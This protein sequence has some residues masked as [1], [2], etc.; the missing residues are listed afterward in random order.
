MPE[1]KEYQL[2]VVFGLTDE[3]ES[4]LTDQVADTLYG[5]FDTPDQNCVIC[6][7]A[8]GIPHAEFSWKSDS[9]R[10][11]KNELKKELSTR[12]RLRPIFIF[13]EEEE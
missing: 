2:Q 9:L 8:C 1:Q 10:H 5:E 11:A 7:D 4:P 6:G 12:L 3:G 13:E